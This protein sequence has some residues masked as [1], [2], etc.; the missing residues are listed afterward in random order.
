MFHVSLKIKDFELLRVG[1]NILGCLQAFMS[2]YPY[3][4]QSITQMSNKREYQKD[5]LNFRFFLTE[6]KNLSSSYTIIQHSIVF[7][8]GLPWKPFFKNWA[9]FFHYQLL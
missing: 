5:N 2:L 8:L 9:G 3:V 7:G 1:Q 4:L 6:Q